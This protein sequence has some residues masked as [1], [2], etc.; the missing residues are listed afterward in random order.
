MFRTQSYQIVH[1]NQTSLLYHIKAFEMF[2]QVMKVCKCER[3]SVNWGMKVCYSL[4]LRHITQQSHKRVH[5]SIS[6]AYGF[7]VRGE[8]HESWIET[9]RMATSD[10]LRTLPLNTQRL[11]HEVS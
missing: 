9:R 7:A 11:L 10:H 8:A 1:N 2:V 4:L 3:T 6:P 5:A